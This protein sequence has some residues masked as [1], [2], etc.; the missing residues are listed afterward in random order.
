LIGG[1]MVA[2]NNRV[3]R[4]AA[5]WS[6]FLD[7]GD[8]AHVEH[9]VGFIDHQHVAAVEHDL[10]ALEQVHQPPGVAISTSTPLCSAFT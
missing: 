3:W 2:L 9:A 4:C 8:E 6:R 5:A 10:A 7:V 1:G